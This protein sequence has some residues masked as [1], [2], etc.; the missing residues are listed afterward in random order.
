MRVIISL[1]FFVA[2]GLIFLDLS[3]SIPEIASDYVIFFQFLPSLL[4]FL[5]PG[6]V[7]A[8][9][10][11]VVIGLTLVFGR[12]YCSFLC[13]LGVLQDIMMYTR[14]KIHKIQFTY[15][16]PHNTVRYGIL[17]LVVLSAITGSVI[18]LTAID[19]YS[20]FGRIL[21]HLVKPVAVL[22]SN[23]LVF[24]LEKI[25]LYAVSPTE[26]KGIAFFPFIFSVLIFS[27]I[28]YMACQN[29]RLY[30]NTICPVG[31]FLGFLSRV[32]LLKI[33][34]KPA[35]CIRCKACERV[36][37][38]GCINADNMS[39][40]FSRCIACYN[41]L[42]VCP[43][44]AVGYQWGFRK[45]KPPVL[46]DTGKR[47][48]ILQVV[49]FF[50]TIA[51]FT[52][53]ARQPIERYK[54]STVPVIRKNAI[55][56]PGSLSLKNFNNKCT[57]CH[58]CVSACPTQVLQPSFLEYGFRG[59]MQPRMDY[60]T[61]YC[62]Y[63]CVICSNVC[64]TGAILNQNPEGKKLIQIG[65]AAFVKENCVVYTHKTDC[66]ACAEHCPTKA[67]RM[68]LDKKIKKRVPEIDENICVGCGACEFACPTKPY[69]AIYVKSNPV[70][71]VARK[72]KEDK[73]KEKVDLKEKFPF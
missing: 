19:P 67:V 13:P 48:F 4:K 8:S 56:P 59:I 24:M 12:V 16:S 3:F 9:G 27:L 18:G 36:C 41:C 23:I 33:R 11:I 2:I 63:D 62:N 28:Q 50:L 38:S 71:A 66:G 61:S 70:H 46:N 32:S 29:G 15:K 17:I 55:S 53:S 52:V 42:E 5:S 43:T 35:E 21:T 30:C 57:A 14:N 10:F 58:L 51:P 25:N 31:T 69:K 65:K 68:V 20:N 73:I 44:S 26:F 72:P 45:N 7:A 54:D 37:K 40:D 60:K 34:F 1:S 47:K 49:T 64:P 39:V 6:T 22:L